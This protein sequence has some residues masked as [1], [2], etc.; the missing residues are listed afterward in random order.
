MT[1]SHVVPGSSEFSSITAAAPQGSW[2]GSVH[3]V[4][5]KE[6]LGRIHETLYIVKQGETLG[7]VLGGSAVLGKTTSENGALPVYAFAPAVDVSNLGD[8]S[9]CRDFGLR[10]PYYAGAMA[11]GIASHE[12]VVAMSRAGMLGF[13]GSAGLAPKAVSAAVD[14]LHA[15][16]GDAPYGVNLIHSPNE[17]DL[18][19]EVV[20]ICLRKAVHTVEASAYMNLTLAVVRYRVHGIHR[21]AQG[22][23]VAP[24]RIVAKVS[25]VEVATR[26]FSPAPEK[27]LAKLVEAGEITAEQAAMAGE[28]PMAQD[29]SAEADSGG[30]TDRRPAM[31]LLP[32]MMAL[33]DEL[34]AKYGYT[35]PL[36]VGLGGGVS[37]P[38]SAAAAFAMGAAF[39]VTGSVNQACRESGSSDLVRQMLAESKQADVAMAPAADMFEMGVTV[40]VLKRGTM[41]PVR[42]AKLYEIYRS[43]GSI[44]EIPADDRAKIEEQIFRAPLDEIWEQTRTFFAERDPRQLERA[45][46]NPKHKMALVFRWYLGQSSR[47]ANAGVPDRQVD[48]QIW[49]GPSMGAFNEWVK[50]SYLESWENRRVV[51]VALNILY[52]AAVLTRGHCLRTQGVAPSPDVERI[53]PQEQTALEELLS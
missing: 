29:I 30:H 25:R 23:V 27:F 9:F 20:D 13:F 34:Q 10:Y 51:A 45:A 4:P 26:F 28:I 40:Q 33:R 43:C 53:V 16:L 14:R 42:A 18:E 3:S 36:R 5:L 48:Y 35:Q 50:G 49:C 22:E 24:N 31:A 1:I 52:G 41:F 15:E 7:P 39:V 17:P 12:V 46:K 6:A 32:T 47:W 11:N 19:S 44:E 2:S 37:T 8:P 38:A 21:N